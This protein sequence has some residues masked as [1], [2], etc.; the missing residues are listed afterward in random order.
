M[1][2]GAKDR[3]ISA[4]TATEGVM[5]LGAENLGVTASTA[6]AQNVKVSVIVHLVTEIVGL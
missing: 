5:G 1:G 4:D 3:I 2:L 6:T